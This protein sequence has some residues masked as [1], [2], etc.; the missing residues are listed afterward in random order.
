MSW[1][2]LLWCA[3]ESL[4]AGWTEDLDARLQAHNTGKG[5]KYTRSRRP[6][7][8]VWREWVPDRRAA[9]RREAALK[10]LSRKEKLALVAG[11]ETDGMEIERKWKIAGFPEGLEELGSA[12]VE[13]SY[14]SV[15]PVVRI[16]KKETLNGCDYRLCLKGEG[17]LVREEVEL[18][19]SE[20]E[21][22]RLLALVKGTPIQKEF[23]TYRLPEGLVL[24]CSLVDA[25]TP[26]AFFYA[27][28]EFSS[29]E[30]ALAYQPPA[31]LGEEWTGQPGRSMS[32][33][34]ARTRWG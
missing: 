4:Y 23:R 9:L 8:L 33:Y 26:N 24:E 14:L 17:T 34:W 19:L 18:P 30:E 22:Q 20:S 32:D 11:Q 16:R 10:Q 5:A 3:D 7:R 12:R 31:F 27:E 15:K 13:Q 2:Y 1:V 29:V 25:G 21:Y 28:V 6:V